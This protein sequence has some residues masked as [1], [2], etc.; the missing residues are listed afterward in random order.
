MRAEAPKLL[1]S[2][3][4]PGLAAHVGLRRG[5]AGGPPRPPTAQAGPPT[6]LPRPHRGGD[7][8]RSWSGCP[9]RCQWRR[10]RRREGWRTGRLR[11][12]RVL[13]AHAPGGDGGPGQVGGDAQQSSELMRFSDQL[14]AAVE[15]MFDPYLQK[16][17]CE[18]ERSCRF[19]WQGG[20]ALRRAAT[21]QEGRR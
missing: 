1:F 7:G 16:V 3:P 20:R 15:S 21:A 18:S 8:G 19:C 6:V 13:D 14:R 12:T 17:S 9:Q 2:R 5:L 4:P 10:Q 11:G